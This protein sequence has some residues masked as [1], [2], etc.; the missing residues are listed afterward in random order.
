MALI[1]GK[2]SVAA[3]QR[4]T[5]FRVIESLETRLPVNEIEIHPVVIGVA[6]HAI[7]SCGALWQK[8]RVQAAMFCKAHAN[9]RVA[10]ET[11]KLRTSERY[12]VTIGAMRRT[13]QETVRLGQRPRRYL[14]M[15]D[16]RAR[17]ESK[18]EEQ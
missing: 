7:L 12:G 4:I 2:S 13:L 17:A 18:C 16:Q 1:A 8:A 14:R 5:G 6:R 9:F 3:R 15:C 11:F 10:I